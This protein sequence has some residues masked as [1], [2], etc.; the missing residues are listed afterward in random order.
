MENWR[1][2][3]HE[4]EDQECRLGIYGCVICPSVMRAQATQ[5]GLCQTVCHIDNVTWVLFFVPV[6]Q[7]RKLVCVKLA[8]LQHHFRMLSVQV[9][10][11]GVVLSTA[12]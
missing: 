3:R 12:V 4:I 6:L 1:G 11:G 5:H 2:K 9:G 8:Q 7:M 10:V